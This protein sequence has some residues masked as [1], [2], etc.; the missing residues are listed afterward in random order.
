MF[1]R[2][3]SVLVA[4]VIAACASRSSA[5]LIASDTASDAA[6]NS[7]WAAG[8]NGG[9]GWGGGW[10]FAEN[11]SGTRGKFVGTSKNN[12]DGDGNA[13][14][15]IDTAN[16][17]W[18][19]F[20]NGGGE[21]FA[22]RPF[23]GALSVG[24]SFI[25]NMDNG[26]IDTSSVIG[27]RFVS[28]TSTITAATREFE[29]RFVGGA[30]AYE[31]FGSTAQASTLGFTDSG[32]LMMFTLTSSSTYSISVTRYHDT[33]ANQVWGTTGSLIGGQ[34]I[35]GVALRNQNAGS[36][37]TKDGFFNNMSITP[38]PASLGLLAMGMLMIRRRSR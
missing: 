28:N 34:P 19:L 36:G 13:N 26:F 37:S 21:I 22:V 38:E 5:S 6:Y 12:G 3:V 2:S 20:A 14:G 1:Q 8:S 10:S 24:Q 11:A 23:S 17:A 25:I 30:S 15:D 4:F 7:G 16:R 27:V 32:L 18:G 33:Q 31:A 9:T 29:F 35:L